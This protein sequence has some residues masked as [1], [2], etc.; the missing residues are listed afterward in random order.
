MITVR[1]LTKTYQIRRGGFWGRRHA[2]VHALS[3]ISLDIAA[4]SM[5]GLIGPNGAGKST[6]T[7]ILCG[8]LVPDGGSCLVAGRVPWRERQAHVAGIGVVFGQRS[9]LWWDL[10]V[11]DTFHL[12][13]EIHRLPHRDRDATIALLASD[14]GISDLLRQPV[15]QLSLGQR[16]R[17]ELVAAL[18][19]RPALLLLDEPTIGLD[20]PA[21]LAL[22]DLLRRINRERGTTIL[23]ATHDL[24]DIEAVCPR[25]LV[26]AGGRL[27]LDGTPEVL[28]ARGGARRRIAVVYDAEARDPQ[29]P[30]FQVTECAGNRLRGELDVAGAEVGTALARL[31]AIG[32]VVDLTVEP[33]PI[34]EVVAKLYQEAG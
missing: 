16:M 13:G 33:P 2:E 26:I 20:A 31:S 22:R 25:V 10:P 9:Q 28:R 21:K 23:L 19:H 30:G 12:L 7:K 5:V 18:L 17:C 1:D 27:L 6:L 34:D 14:M 15:R 24:D 29:V 32:R 11:A 8:I 3:S 4:G